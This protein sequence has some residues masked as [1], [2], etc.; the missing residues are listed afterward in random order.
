[1]KIECVDALGVFIQT[2]KRIKII[3][4]GRASTKSTFV[5]DYVLT[6]IDEG[7]KWCCGREYQASIE[8]SV[9]SLL[10]DEID[11]CGFT[12]FNVGASDIN[13]TSGGRA[14]YRGLS[15]NITS[16]K[17][18]NVHGL[19]IEEGESLS[20][21]T[22]KVL[23]ASI[24]VSAKD[25]QAALL[26]GEEILTPEIWIT[27][28][29]GSSNDPIAK[30]FLARAEKDLKRTGYYEDDMVMIVQ[31]NYNDNPWFEYSGLEA[32]RL[33]DK[34]NE[35][36]AYYEH[37]WGGAYSDTV[38]NAI[39]QPHWFDACI[40][41]HIKLGFEPTGVEVVTHDPS[42]LGSDPK[43]LSY[44]HG[45]VFLDVQEDDK[46]DVNEGADRA[47]EF[48]EEKRP[49]AFI[50]DGGGMGVSLRRQFNDS[51][52]PK[53][54]QV[55]MFN[56]AETAMRPE[57][58]YEDGLDNKEHKKTNKQTFTNQ[59]AQFYWEVRDRCYR[60]YQAVVKGKYINPDELI[61]FSSDIEAIDLLRAELCS[62]PKKYNSIGKIQIM[63]KPEMKALKIDSPNM[64]DSVM[65]SFSYNPEKVKKV[66]PL[67]QSAR[68]FGA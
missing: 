39:I 41:A 13:H 8:D 11:R 24:R 31:I 55:Q 58:I 21:A 10:K 42:D 63:T 33:D 64:A 50:W 37:K 61:S 2:K 12:G 1:M 20:K 43:G 4:G 65:M 66:I 49:D 54:I 51:L 53:N 35:S 47:I 5:S 28:N 67:M 44:R 45:V 18:L 6:K 23:T 56:G 7:E 19:W 9:H 14:F 27:M 52:G 29:R 68:K 38:D 57:E 36:P 48:C 34:E 16:L 17:G 26:A 46:G 25:V 30:K 32:E 22:L 3:I 40:D 60:T 62:I 59:R 15:R